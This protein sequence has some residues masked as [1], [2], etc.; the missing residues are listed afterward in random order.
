MHRNKSKKIFKNRFGHFRAGWRIIIC[1]GITIA[2]FIPFAGLM[3]LWN[4]LIPETGGSGGSNDFASF[5]N[6]I[7]FIALNISIIFGF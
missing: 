4:L 6:I 5:V 1:L 2:T 7:F 3:K